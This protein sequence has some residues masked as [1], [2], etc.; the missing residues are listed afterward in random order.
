MNEII[1]EYLIDNYQFTTNIDGW[2]VFDKHKKKRIV[3]QRLIKDMERVFPN[4]GTTKICTMWWAKNITLNTRKIYDYLKGYKLVQSNGTRAWVVMKGPKKF[5]L[6]D[7]SEILPKHFNPQGVKKV[8]DEWY[9]EELYR[10]CKLLM[11]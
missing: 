6:D 10:A 1:T 4:M 5:N 11:K 3:F 7:L 9:E 2:C 8:Y